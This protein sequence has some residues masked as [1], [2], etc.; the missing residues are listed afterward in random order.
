MGLVPV[1]PVPRANDRVRLLCRQS[2]QQTDSVIL[3]M[4]RDRRCRGSCHIASVS[5]KRSMPAI[6]ESIPV[7]FAAAR[8]L[9]CGNGSPLQHSCLCQRMRQ[10]ADLGRRSSIW[11]IER[12]YDVRPTARFQ[13]RFRA[14]RVRAVRVSVPSRAFPTESVIAE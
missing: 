4:M 1:G 7:K 2:A 6:C 13:Q 11:S 3:R 12:V 8:A 5:A 9:M 10:T 14:L